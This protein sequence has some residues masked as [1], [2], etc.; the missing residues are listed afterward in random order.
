[1]SFLQCKKQ[2]YQKNYGILSIFLFFTIM[3]IPD[4]LQ[5]GDSVMLVAP[6]KKIQAEVIE[7]ATSILEKW[8]LKVHVGKY[9]T[10][11]H[12]WFAGTDSERIQDMQQA[13]DN[14]HVKAII[15]LR[16]GYGTS[17]II[18][19]LDFTKFTQH[20]KWI[21]GFSDITILHAK[22]S[23]YNTASIHGTMPIL[24]D[25]END[26]MSLDTLKKALFG[27]LN[28]YTLSTHP[29]NKQGIAQGRLVGGNLAL[30]NVAIGTSYDVDTQNAILFIEDIDEYAYNIDRMMIHLK[31]AGKL[32]YLAG[33]IVGYMT[34]IKES[35]D[36][37]FGKEAYQ[38]IEE[39]V[40]EYN[41]P[42]CYHF[43][44]GHEPDNYALYLNRSATLKIEHNQVILSW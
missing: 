34:N 7:K 10:N 23:Q 12:Y 30:L 33:L 16:G 8:G 9:A 38:I 18:T 29:K 14:P 1:M 31:H 39:V 2:I 6:A 24:F 13:L 37:F 36:K 4:Y 43:P 32:E 25:E 42:I 35:E 17:R 3:I 26:F 5:K 41:Y 19:Q 22:L 21:V 40:S 27:E 44:A 20:P 28:H 11:E 15:A